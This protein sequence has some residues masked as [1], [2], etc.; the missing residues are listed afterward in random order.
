MSGTKAVCYSLVMQHT[1]SHLVSPEAGLMAM[2]TIVV[3]GQGLTAG[4]FDV[5][6]LA[7]RLSLALDPSSTSM[8]AST[9]FESWQR[10]RKSQIQQALDYT[11]KIGAILEERNPVKVFLR[12]WLLWSLQLIPILRGIIQEQ[13]IESPRYDHAEG[14]AFLPNLGGGRAFFQIYCR[15]LNHPKVM[16]SDSVIFAAQKKSLFQIVVLASSVKNARSECDVLDRLAVKHRHWKDIIEE[17]TIVVHDLEANMSDIEYC[18]PQQVVRPA[19]SEEFSSS[20]LCEGRAIP[21]GYDPFLL[22]SQHPNK[23][24]VVV[25]PDIFTFA[26]CANTTE[27]LFALEEMGKI[28]G[29][30]ARQTVR[31]PEG[32]GVNAEAAA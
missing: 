32:C 1:C 10:E 18:Y 3:G 2:L 14:M 4:F 17:A 30:E 27:M 25:R 24:Y 28:S 31:D 20:A 12:D 5:V 11:M 13:P 16:F 8:D 19:T 9:L 26:A 22:R 7:W 29:C 23:T 15:S 6:G 21:L